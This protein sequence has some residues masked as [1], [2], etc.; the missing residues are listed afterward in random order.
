MPVILLGALGGLAT[1]GI[2]GMFV[3]ATVLTL[4]YQI[5]MGWVAADLNSGQAQ[6]ASDEHS[7][8]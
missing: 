3:G 1:S 6:A 4:G 8:S 5:F 7:E 2:Q